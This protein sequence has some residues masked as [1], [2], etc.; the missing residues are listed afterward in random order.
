MKYGLQGGISSHRTWYLKSKSAAAKMERRSLAD[1]RI[2]RE[3]EDRV[4][5]RVV[6][7]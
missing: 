7:R 6:G 5:R 2:Y 4:F 3:R 1:R